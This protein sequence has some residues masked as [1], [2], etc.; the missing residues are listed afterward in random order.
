MCGINSYTGFYYTLS[1]C[2]KSKIANSSIHI[3]KLIITYDE[4][5]YKIVNCNI[6]QVKLVSISLMIT[7]YIQQLYLLT[8]VLSY[9]IF[10][11]AYFYHGVWVWVSGW[12]GN[13][14]TG[15]V[16]SSWGNSL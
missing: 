13:G 4:V 7:H 1:Q 12:L 11:I 9:F 8:H 15:W 14:G 6:S 10:Q 3:Y 5:K 16:I 2:G